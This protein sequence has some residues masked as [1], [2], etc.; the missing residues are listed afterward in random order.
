VTVNVVSL[1][2]SDSLSLAVGY[3]AVWVTGIGVT[4]QVDEA[5]GRIVRTVSTPGTFP[6]GCGSGIAAGAGGAWVSYGCR[7]VPDQ[8]S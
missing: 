4:Y 7:G 5:A 3:G 2:K 1:P 6:N 8:P